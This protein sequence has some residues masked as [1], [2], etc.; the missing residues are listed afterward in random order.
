MTKEFFAKVGEFD[1]WYGLPFDPNKLDDPNDIGLTVID[2]NKN[3]LFEKTCSLDRTEFYWSYRD[4]I[5]TF[6]VEEISSDGCLYDH[7]YFNRYVHSERNIQEKKFR[8]LDGAVKVYL[9]DI[10]QRRKD[11]FIPKE[12]KSHNKVKLWRIDGNIDLQT[13]SLLI[14][15]FF[16]SNEMVIKYFDPEQ[17]E[18][19]FELRVRDVVEWQR[20]QS[21]QASNI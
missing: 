21:A 19:I 7:Y 16:K 18:E 3:S 1:T 9:Q 2:R 14:S 4:G 12:L 15:S 5:K 11:S 10:Y 13:W 8:H 20:Q 6:E 17:F